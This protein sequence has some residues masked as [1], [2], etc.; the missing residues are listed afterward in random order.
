MINNND[1]DD[2]GLMIYNDDLQWWL[3]YWLSFL[4]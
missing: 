3:Q 4:Q 1:F 2:G